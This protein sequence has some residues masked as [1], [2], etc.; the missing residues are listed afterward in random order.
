MLVRAA[1]PP[2]R[3]AV[4]ALHE[5]EWGGPYVIAHDVRYDLRELPTLVAVDGAVD[6]TATVLGALV[7]RADDD[8]LEVVSIVADSS[9]G[10][11]G[12]T[13]LAAAI[14]E[15]RARRAGRLWLITSNDNLR[16]LRFYQRR[17][18]RIVAVDRGAVD[19]ARR[20]KPTIPTVGEDGIPLHD[21]LVLELRL[22]PEPTD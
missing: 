11:V 13:L 10:G 15:S 3:I 1:E 9:G 17:G 16:A 6:G 19:R 4:D 20:L 22:A 21:E 7:W 5:R 18:L 2:D 8:G 14:E 12:S